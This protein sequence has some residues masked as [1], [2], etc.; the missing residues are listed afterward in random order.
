MQFPVL[1]T[2]ARWLKGLTTVFT[3]LVLSLGFDDRPRKKVHLVCLTYSFSP[4]ALLF[5]KPNTV[6]VINLGAS[7][8][9]GQLWLIRNCLFVGQ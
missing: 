6:K 2:H 9:A 1:V 8:D 7:Q 4:I 5:Q 3:R